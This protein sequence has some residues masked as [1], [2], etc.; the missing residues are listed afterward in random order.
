MKFKQGD[1]VRI[2]RISP[3]VGETP[4]EYEQFVGGCGVITRVWDGA[5]YPYEIGSVTKFTCWRDDELEL[6]NQKTIWL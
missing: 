6:V 2:V 4:E 5:M 3:G 1:K